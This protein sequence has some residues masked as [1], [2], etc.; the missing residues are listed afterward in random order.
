MFLFLNV[1][2]NVFWTF[3]IENNLKQS[4]RKSGNK[5]KTDSILKECE[6]RIKRQKIALDH[7]ESM[8]KAT[9]SVM[10][11]YLFVLWI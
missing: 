1:E 11:L 7:E 8:N 3:F 4:E 9:G 5:S 6:V 10:S 2:I